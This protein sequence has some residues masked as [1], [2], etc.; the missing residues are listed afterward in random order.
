MG[1]ESI[2]LLCGYDACYTSVTLR[3]AD[4]FSSQ[5]L[6]QPVCGIKLQLHLAHARQQG[7]HIVQVELTVAC[8]NSRLEPFFF[9]FRDFT[10]GRHLNDPLG[11]HRAINHR[12]ILVRLTE[13]PYQLGYLSRDCT[14]RQRALKQQIN[15]NIL[16]MQAFCPFLLLVRQVKIIHSRL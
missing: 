12:L 2:C 15:I 5:R 9:V 10:A 3:I 6:D 1:S 14:R 7:L 13:L 16:R 11:G 4:V 8:G